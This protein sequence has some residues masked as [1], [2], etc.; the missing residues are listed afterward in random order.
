MLKRTAKIVLWTIIVIEISWHAS[1][2]EKYIKV[3]DDLFQEETRKKNKNVSIPPGKYFFLLF[4]PFW[5]FSSFL[6]FF[7]FCHRLSWFIQ[8]H[9]LLVTVFLC[10]NVTKKKCPFLELR[11]YGLFK[12]HLPLYLNL[13]ANS[14]SVN[15]FCS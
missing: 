3:V 2:K 4:F 15:I 13:L 8:L 10:R 1:N 6:F 7:F 11:M 14:L 9:W 12:A 5:V